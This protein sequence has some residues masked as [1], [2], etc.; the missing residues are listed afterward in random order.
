MHQFDGNYGKLIRSLRGSHTQATLN[1]KLSYRSNQVNR[2][3]SQR[4]CPTWKQFVNL[5]SALD[6]NLKRIIRN[7]HDLEF[8]PEHPH[9]IFTPLT[10]TR[11]LKE[12]AQHLQVSESTIQR[13]CN[14]QSQPSLLAVLALLDLIPGKSQQF[15]RL[16][17]KESK[18]S[19]GATYN[20]RV[21]DAAELVLK[22]PVT[23][24]ISAFCDLDHSLK[25]TFDHQ[26]LANALGV[27]LEEVMQII[28]ELVR[29]QAIED[30][31]S[32]IN[33]EV[34]LDTSSLSP[35]KRIQIRAFWFSKIEQA[36][37]AKRLVLHE[38]SRLRYMLHAVS[39]EA[40]EE[41]NR[42]ISQLYREIDHLIQNQDKTKRT[43]LSYIG[44]DLI[45]VF[46]LGTEP[47]NPGTAI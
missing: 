35:E 25:D 42:R 37:R 22:H 45:D 24:A 7:L 10:R 20:D 34:V 16:L 11:S 14:G 13:W 23:G 38:T 12:S 47:V 44:L 3:E 1:K 36:I 4:R 40:H 28:Q 6:L 8:D 46:K 31:M 17:I 30:E 33:R 41:I 27:S 43:R 15:I 39:E 32:Y 29:L 21:I 5:C 19:Q 18:A 9:T 2:W 26:Q